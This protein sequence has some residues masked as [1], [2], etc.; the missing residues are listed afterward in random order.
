M[1]LALNKY[2]MRVEKGL[3]NV[4][5]EDQEKI[6]ALEAQLETLIKARGKQHSGSGKSGTQNKA[7]AK[8]VNH[9]LSQPGCMS[10]RTW[11]A[12]KEDI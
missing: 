2:K 9:M 10:R 11:R 5:T 8:Q 6:I 12:D 1:H 3:W 4:P 7:K